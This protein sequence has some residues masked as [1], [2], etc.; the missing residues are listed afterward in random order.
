MAQT[1]HATV[2]LWARDDLCA[3][4]SGEFNFELIV[5]SQLIVEYR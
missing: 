3:H 2:R 5:C 1:G 4:E